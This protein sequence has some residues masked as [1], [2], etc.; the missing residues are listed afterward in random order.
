MFKH[1][2]SVKVSKA[3]PKEIELFKKAEKEAIERSKRI[4]SVSCPTC[5]QLIYV[6]IK[7]EQKTR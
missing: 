2:L 4:K 5:N 7:K 6:E 3:T 1:R